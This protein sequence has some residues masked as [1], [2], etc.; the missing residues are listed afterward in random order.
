MLHFENT[1]LFRGGRKNNAIFRIENI[2]PDRIRNLFNGS[3]RIIKAVDATV[4]ERMT[5]REGAGGA[6]RRVMCVPFSTS[7]VAFWFLPAGCRWPPSGPRWQLIKDVWFAGDYLARKFEPRAAGCDVFERPWEWLDRPLHLWASRSRKF[8]I[9]AADDQ[10]TC[11]SFA[12][13]LVRERLRRHVIELIELL[14][15]PNRI[16]HSH[17]TSVYNG[18]CISFSSENKLR[19]TIHTTVQE[20]SNS[21]HEQRRYGTSKSTI[22]SCLQQFFCVKLQCVI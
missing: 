1:T 22:G 4:I 21:M 13:V 2:S 20:P 14:S 8:Q 16:P 18:L 15:K 17:A 7:Q 19:D 11:H 5:V 6:R 9:S 3:S 12:F 10:C